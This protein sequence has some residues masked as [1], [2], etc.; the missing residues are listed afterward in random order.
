MLRSVFLK[1]LRD[2]WVGVLVASGSLFVVAWMGLWAYSDIGDEAN[3]FFNTMPEAYRAIFGLSEEGG[4]ASLM[5]AQVNNFL[6]PLIL[7]GI[8]VSIGAAAVAGEERRGTIDVLATVPRSRSRLL[9]SKLAAMVALTVVAGVLTWLGSLAAVAMTGVD[10]GGAHLG[11]A[12]V[13]LVALALFFG[14][15]ALAVG[16]WTGQQ[17]LASGAAT[18]LLVVSFL[19]AGLLPLIDSLAD[20]ARAFPWYY[21]NAHQPLLNGVNGGDLAV[22][23]GGAALL[24]GAAFVGVNR[25][26][27]RRG[28]AS[29]P[30]LERL[31]GVPMLQTALARL[32]GSGATAGV[33]A[34]TLSE[35]RAVTIIAGGGLFFMLVVMGPMYLAIKDSI[36]DL[37]SSMPEQ[38]L[39]IVGFVDYTRPEGW[40]HGESM[41]ILVPVAALVVAISMAVRS[42]AGEERAR[43]ADVL[44][45]HPISR[46]SLAW[47]KAAAMVLMVTLVGVL[48]S[49][50]IAVGNLVSGLGMSYLRI[51]ETGA[52]AAAFGWCVGA[53]AFFAGAATGRAQVALGAGVGVAVLGWGVQSFAAVS[54]ALKPWA[55]AS[56]YYY[57]LSNYPLDNG[58][59][60][61]HLAALVGAAAVLLVA[62]VALYNRRDLR[63]G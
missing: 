30:L 46:T 35:A 59:V 41:T 3:D 15:F 29:T 16:A 45:A 49:T 10:A 50:G 53:V 11:A 57:L 21:L 32:S 43:W 34:K 55:P 14:A 24:V 52:L 28:E 56:P 58:L 36:G 8:A 31:R 25:R 37:V 9:G 48:V 33:I 2:R 62:G 1:S 39:A 26:D 23:L 40:Y 38:I 7:G 22:L 27:L 18:A 61:W 51:L 12:A 63:A 54:D 13:H 19:G 5:F 4:L 17:Q 60:P 42:L 20:V 44:L 6:G 47:R